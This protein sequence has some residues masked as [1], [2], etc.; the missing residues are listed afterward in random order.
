MFEKGEGKRGLTRER[1]SHKNFADPSSEVILRKEEKIGLD[2]PNRG[3]DEY[4]PGRRQER[5]IYTW[6]V[7]P[8][9]SSTV[10][11]RRVPTQVES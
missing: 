1:G 8:I 2:S 11:A 6:R 5:R 4:Q 3:T 10:L 7:C 9:P